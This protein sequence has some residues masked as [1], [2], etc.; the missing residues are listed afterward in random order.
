MA[1]IGSF[2]GFHRRLAEARIGG[3][4]TAVMKTLQITILAA[5]L[6][7]CASTGG[8]ETAC[9]NLNRDVGENAKGIS[10]VAISRGN[11]DALSVPFW[12][13]GGKKAVTVI[14]DRQTA[15]IEKLQARQTTLLAD[16][17]QSCQ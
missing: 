1:V 7:G 15:R 16:R 17:E 9:A 3:M 5:A 2:P 4:F 13:P 10:R 11:V 12:V 6:A 14:T 8:P